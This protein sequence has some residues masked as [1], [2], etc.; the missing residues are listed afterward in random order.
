LITL[1]ANVRPGTDA[2]RALSDIKALLAE[3]FGI[4]HS[5]VQ[6]EPDACADR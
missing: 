4:H 1:H 3:R 5:T 2:S 6:I